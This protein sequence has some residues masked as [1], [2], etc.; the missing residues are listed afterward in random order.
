M[1][2]DM[3]CHQQAAGHFS[4]RCSGPSVI[5]PLRN[6]EHCKLCISVLGLS[7]VCPRKGSAPD[8]CTMLWR[9]CGLSSRTA[10]S[11]RTASTALDVLGSPASELGASAHGRDCLLICNSP[12]IELHCPHKDRN[13]CQTTFNENYGAR[14]HLRQSDDTIT[15]SH[16]GTGF[17]EM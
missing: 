14:C 13:I 1:P 6:G 4:Q 15:A 16:L 9:L 10:P 2:A 5:R 8:I 7:T 17:L 12:D 11:R 3:L